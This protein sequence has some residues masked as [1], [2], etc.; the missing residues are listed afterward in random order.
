MIIVQIGTNNGVDPCSE[1]VLANKDKITELH[2][3]E[4]Q[5]ACNT[6]IDK[7]YEDVS[8]VEIYNI[9]ISDNPLISELTIYFPTANTIS[10]HS[11]SDYNH[12]I[13]HNHRDISCITVPAYTL[14]KFFD[15]NGITHCD[16]LYIDTEGLDCKILLGFNF[17]KYGINYIEFETIHADGAFNKGESYNRC[18]DKFR[19]LGYEIKDAGEFNQCAVK[20]HE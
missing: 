4:P 14:E 3:I 8:N 15:L 7:V 18:V 19:S 20:N 1:F 12:L 13:A 5:S 10:G 16:R 9:A 2:L 6:H 11:S 17:A